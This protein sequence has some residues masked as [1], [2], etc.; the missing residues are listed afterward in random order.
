[1]FEGTSDKL[2]SDI[3]LARVTLQ[4]KWLRSFGQSRLIFRTELGALATDNF[5]QVPSSLRFFA[6]GD[7]S[8]RGF[9][10]QTLAPR[11][12]EGELIGGRYLYTGSV[13]YAYPFADNWRL[14]MFID[15]GNAGDEMFD[16]PATGYG[17]G[18]HWSTVVGPVRVYLARGEN[19]IENTWRMHFSLG[20]AL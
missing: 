7:Q 10:Y 15:A 5:T 2:L 8:V 18:I 3:D 13:E 14:A 16:N 19:E 20:G 9:G 17:L 1:M 12:S 6:G 11:N 4:S